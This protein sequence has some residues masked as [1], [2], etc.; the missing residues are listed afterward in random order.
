MLPDMDS[1]TLTPDMERFV[2]EVVA[3]GRY[4]DASDVVRTGIALLQRVEAERAAFI[5]SLH[6]A[7]A[8]GERDGFFTLDEVMQEMDGIIEEAE[9]RLA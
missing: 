7:E 6:E 2:A 9:R 4:S 8:E 3:G 5:A 1:V